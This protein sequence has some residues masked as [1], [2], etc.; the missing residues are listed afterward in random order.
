VQ[1]LPPAALSELRRTP[2]SRVL[3]LSVD[4]GR[5]DYALTTAGGPRYG[6]GTLSVPDGPARVLAGFVRDVAAPRGTSAA[7]GLA[8]F[9]VRYVAVRKPVPLGLAAALD[10]QA[11]L[12]RLDFASE[13]Q[14]WRTLTPSAHLLVVP[15][16]L[17]RSAKAGQLPSRDEFRD[18]PLITLPS[19]VTSARV[20][21]LPG[22][23]GRLLVLSERADDGWIAEMDGRRLTRTTAWGWAQAYEL[24]ERGGQLVV[25]RDGSRRA[26]LLGLQGLLLLVAVVLAAPSVRRGETEDGPAPAEDSEQELAVAGTS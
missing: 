12:S 6:D 7:D 19:G 3:W 17:A 5:I 8:T 23:P 16:D 25:R 11:G 20:T 18:S 13:V 26:G 10:S 9:A 22:G 15:A 14:L 4:A 21:M 1:A 24:P 2:G